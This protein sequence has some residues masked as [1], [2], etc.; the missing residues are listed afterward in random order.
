MSKLISYRFLS[1]LKVMTFQGFVH[2]IRM[3]FVSLTSINNLNKQYRIRNGVH[4]GYQALSLCCCVSEQ[5]GVFW[6]WLGVGESPNRKIL[7][8]TSVTQGGFMTNSN[9]RNTV[10][11]PDTEKLSW[12][13]LLP[14][15]NSE[16]RNIDI[17]GMYG[18]PSV[19]SMKFWSGVAC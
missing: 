6:N 3:H 8:F 19:S 9:I 15:V 11:L 14:S 1:L 12:W 17:P 7:I 18:H 13:L 2:H 10:D 4:A 5:N 16:Q